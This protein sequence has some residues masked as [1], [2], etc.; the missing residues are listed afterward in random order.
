MSSSS[1]SNSE[2]R[3]TKQ[4]VW[5]MGLL[6]LPFVAWL[7]F[8]VAVLTLSGELMVSAD[9]IVEKQKD[10]YHPVLVGLAYS[11]P[12]AMF[13]L[14]SVQMRD[15]HVLVLGT[16]RVMQFRQGFFRPEVS[17]YNAGG[18]ISMLWELEEFFRQAT[19]Y[20]RVDVIVLGLDQWEFN[21]AWQ[22]QEFRQRISPYTAYKDPNPLQVIQANW[23]AVYE[24]YGDGKFK[25]GDLFARH[26]YATI[27]LQA[28][29]WQAGFRNDGGYSER[30][31]IRLVGQ[32]DPANIDHGF[33]ATLRRIGKGTERFEYGQ[34]ASRQRAD[35]L[36]PFLVECHRRGIHVT[37]FLPPFA[38]TVD[39]RIEAEGEK[40]AYMKEIPRLIRP[41]LDGYGFAFMDFSDISSLGSNDAEFLDGFHGSEKAYFRLMMAMTASDPVIAGIVDSSRLR[42]LLR[43]TKSD[44]SVFGD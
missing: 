43:D 15:A 9:A 20:K 28:M 2:H 32:S 1:I 16:S 36:L 22:A 34:T 44:C 7:G 4:F 11:N 38:P 3:T 13:K 42:Q 33:Q 10:P 19:A 6:M 30:G 21:D 23:R 18:G 12:T 31:G 40:Y 27:G 5:K 37:A 35:S 29:A 25:M 17:F 41:L 14:R 8:P 26:P 24:A 39:R